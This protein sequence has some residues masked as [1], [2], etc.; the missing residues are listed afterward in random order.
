MY[1]FAKYHFLSFEVAAQWA[2]FRRRIGNFLSGSNWVK[3]WRA[4]SLPIFCRPTKISTCGLV[5]GE[6]KQ[7]YD[8]IEPCR[9]ISGSARFQLVGWCAAHQDNL[10]QKSRQV[11]I[12]VS[13]DEKSANVR[14]PL[15][16]LC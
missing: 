8:K 14:R 15:V 9:A 2:I 12:F 10:S 7:G 6:F 1:H 4:V 11:E 13:A 5:W 16:S 3:I